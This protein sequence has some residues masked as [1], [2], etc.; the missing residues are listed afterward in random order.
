MSNRNDAS[1]RRIDYLRGIKDRLSTDVV[2]AFFHGRTSD[3]IYISAEHPAQFVL[4]PDDVEKGALSLRIKT[5]QYV[6]ITLGAEVIPNYGAEQR[7][8]CDPPTL[9]EVG[10]LV[11]LNVN[12]SSQARNTRLASISYPAAFNSRISFVFQPSES[13]NFV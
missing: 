6:D 10:K 7:Q 12:M 5:D 4:H 11:G 8:F 2:T 1:S 13:S 3:E 9:A